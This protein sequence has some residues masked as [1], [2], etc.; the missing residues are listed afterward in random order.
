M[1]SYKVLQKHLPDTHT[2]LH[3][4]YVIEGGRHCALQ[5]LL[6][7]LKKELSLE[8]KGNP[9]YFYGAYEVCGIPEVRALKDFAQKKPLQND[10]RIFVLGVD[11]FT[12]E[13]Q[14]A[15]LK[16]FEEPSS[17]A[18][19]FVLLPSAHTLLPTL[20]SR[21][22]VVPCRDENFHVGTAQKFLSLSFAAR[23]NFVE[24]WIKEERGVEEAIS[25]VNSLESELY[26][27][28]EKKEVQRALSLVLKC[29]DYLHQQGT[30]KKGVLE[31]LS[32]VLPVLKT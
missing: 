30:T 1:D 2:K 27:H 16:L 5:P 3:H 19:F 9:D 26:I 32:L 20:R 10:I 8:T 18:V 4:A 7:F 13:A 25:L 15:L 24:K 21:V 23:L 14:N 11:R 12:R 31:Y 29:R 6:S 28:R 17:Y 22:M